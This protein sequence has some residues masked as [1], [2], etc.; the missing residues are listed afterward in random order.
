MAILA[1]REKRCHSQLRHASKAISLSQRVKSIEIALRNLGGQAS[2]PKIAA[3]IRRAFA[4]PHPRTLLDSIRGRLQECSSDSKLFRGKHDLFYRVHGIG[5][6][7]WG[8]REIG[9]TAASGGDEPTDNA[10]LPLEGPDFDEIV[11]RLQGGAQPIYGSHAEVQVRHRLAAEIRRLKGVL[12]RLEPA[13]GGIGHNRPPT[14]AQE[15]A[16][17]PDIIVAIAHDATTIDAEVQAENPDA[18]KVAHS[19]RRLQRFAH[20]LSGKADIFTDEF[21]RAFGKSLGKFAG[22]AVATGGLLFV[23]QNVVRSAGQ[24]LQLVLH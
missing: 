4:G 3:E 9:S 7:V 18:L 16:P 12:D 21:A 20:W 11:D 19:A 23:L 1:V 5:S 22:A 24:W 10:Q 17:E 2:T 14:D 6:G 8:L 13:H 15:D